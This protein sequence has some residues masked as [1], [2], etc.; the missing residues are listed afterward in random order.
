MRLM[1]G[2]PGQEAHRISS[3]LGSGGAVHTTGQIT[4]NLAAAL[5][6][7]GGLYDI[8]VRKLPAKLSAMCHGSALAAKLAREL[9]RALGGGLVAVGLTTAAVANINNGY[10]QHSRL[11]LV[12]LL[13]VPS[14]GM[15]AIGMY[16]VGSPFYVP[17]GFIL[18]VL[19]G[20]ML[21]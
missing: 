21:A 2:H 20:E 11:M 18:L 9:L 14:E 8:S 19:L 6:T 16:R 10:D 15:N 12:L 3:R 4:L 7:G 17:L 1:P 5:I 13:V